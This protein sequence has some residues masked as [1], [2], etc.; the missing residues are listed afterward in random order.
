VDALFARCICWVWVNYAMCDQFATVTRMGSDRSDL[1][2]LVDELD[3]QLLNDAAAWL[4][5]LKPA[6]E[7][8]RQRCCFSE[9]DTNATVDCAGSDAACDHVM[10]TSRE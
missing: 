7:V 2:R 8:P 3:E 6:T 1:H 5:T 4:R 9:E 10:L